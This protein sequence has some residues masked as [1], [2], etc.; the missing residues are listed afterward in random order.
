MIWAGL[1]RR[2]SMDGV[3]HQYFRVYAENEV[4]RKESCN[5]QEPVTYQNT[6]DKVKEKVD[7]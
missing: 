6:Y 3:M 5:F 7:A 2:V 1:I 4:E